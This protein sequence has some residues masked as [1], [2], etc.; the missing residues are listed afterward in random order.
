MSMVAVHQMVERVSQLLEEKLGLGGRDMATKLRRGSRLLPR[1]VRDAAG[2]LAR[3]DEKAK[4]PKLRSQI[5]MG[6]VAQDYDICVRHLSAID[7]VSRRR[8]AFMSMVESVGIGILI[9]GIGAIG[10]AWWL[11][12]L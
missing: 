3:A 4:N 2:R 6:R 1:K 12:Y 9:F 5:D 10:L 7:T 11:G 8:G